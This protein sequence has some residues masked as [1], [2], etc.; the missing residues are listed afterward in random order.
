MLK[1]LNAP[2]SAELERLTAQLANDNVR[3][4]YKKLL[5]EFG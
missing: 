3:F 2:L 1:L 4:C 5:G